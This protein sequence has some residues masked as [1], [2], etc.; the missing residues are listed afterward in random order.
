[1]REQD[2][3]SLFTVAKTY[4]I[5]WNQINERIAEIVPMC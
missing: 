2:E 5:E 4:M 1:M 3:A